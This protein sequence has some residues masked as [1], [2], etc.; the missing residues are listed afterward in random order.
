MRQ[1]WLVQ[2]EQ[3]QGAA[4]DMCIVGMQLQHVRKLQPLRHRFVLIVAAALTSLQ[5]QQ[6]QQNTA[7]VARP[8]LLQR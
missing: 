2:P 7:V 5:K 8:M 1:V 4:Y 6:L 3:Q